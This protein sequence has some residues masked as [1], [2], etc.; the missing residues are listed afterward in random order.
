MSYCP[1]GTLSGIVQ[2]TG[3]ISQPILSKIAINDAPP[4]QLSIGP[5][6][7]PPSLVS[8]NIDDTINNSCIYKNKKYDIINIQLCL[9]QHTG[10][11]L[12]S[13]TNE[14]SAEMIITCHNPSANPEIILLCVPIYNTGTASNDKYMRT[15]LHHNNT[16]IATTTL[17]SVLRYENYSDKNDRVIANTQPSFG[18]RTC[19]QTQVDTRT[20]KPYSTYV[21]V[22]PNGIYLLNSDYTRI[23]SSLIKYK[24]PSTITNNRPIIL[25]Y[26]FNEGRLNTITTS[27]EIS[28]QSM[29][30]TTQISTSSDDFQNKFEYFMKN[31]TSV[32]SKKQTRRFT[33]SQ[34]KCIPFNREENLILEN[35]NIY[36]TPGEKNTPLQTIL[37]ENKK[38]Q[39]EEDAKNNNV[40]TQVDKLGTNIA[41][42]IVSAGGILCI[43]G[44]AYAMNAVTK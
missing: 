3:P 26:T 42:G 19:F 31:I 4:L 7:A 24:V 10:Y 41:V 40:M 1:P 17:E 20:T 25:S 18:Y 23:S 27:P 2:L 11:K 14:P 32:Q 12:P 5:R 21:L 44:I 29:M 16:E 37:D 34:Y 6:G 30:Y 43:I 28:Q 39:D 38:K 36:V 9:P 35:G 13:I 8:N 22:L 15:V 33:T